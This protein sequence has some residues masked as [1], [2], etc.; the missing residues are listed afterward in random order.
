MVDLLLCPCEFPE[1]DPKWSRSGECPEAHRPLLN[2]R[3]V[4]DVESLRVRVTNLCLKHHMSLK[5]R[6]A[7]ATVIQ[8]LDGG[9]KPFSNHIFHS[10]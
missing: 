7:L 1:I 3:D 4:T 10:F 5:K 2:G 6:C 9:F 8:Y